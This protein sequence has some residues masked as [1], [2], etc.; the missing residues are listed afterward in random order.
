MTDQDGGIRAINGN[1][2]IVSDKVYMTANSAGRR[3]NGCTEAITPCIVL[4]LATL[5]GTHENLPYGA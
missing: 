1:S 4:D 3:S 5:N 2:E